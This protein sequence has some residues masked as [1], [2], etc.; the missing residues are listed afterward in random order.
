VATVDGKRRQRFEFMEAVYN[1]TQGDRFRFTELGVIA[2]TI[3]LSEQEADQIAQYLVDEGL[4]GW[5]AFGGVIEITHRGIKEVEQARTQPDEPTVH[6]PPFNLIHVEHMSHSQIQ[7]GTEGSV[8]QMA[9]G[10]SSDESNELR[11]FLAALNDV[12]RELELTVDAQAEM[13]AQLATIEAQ[14]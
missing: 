14:L 9:Q 6:F 8:Q 7:Q 2:P 10:V 12:K 13:E 5:A 3:G 4:L 11:N 1:A